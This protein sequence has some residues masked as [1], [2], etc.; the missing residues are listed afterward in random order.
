MSN[1]MPPEFAL[2]TISPTYVRHSMLI[3]LL[4][5]SIFPVGLLVFMIHFGF[6]VALAIGF[7]MAVTIFPW[8]VAKTYG[9]ALT[10][11]VQL[12][13]DKIVFDYITYNQEYSFG[14]MA[15]WKLEKAGKNWRLVALKD[16]SSKLI[17]IAAFPELQNAMQD[18]YRREA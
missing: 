16:G 8:G 6:D 12:H 2:V 13:P 5:G 10:Q 11:T 18:Y 3:G 15:E 14:S 9:R 7:L 17:P 1:V 4:A